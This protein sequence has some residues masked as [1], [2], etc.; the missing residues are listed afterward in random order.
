MKFCLKCTME[1]DE[2]E[3]SF[4]D[5]YKIIR[6]NECRLCI[7]KYRAKYYERNR[8]IIL[9][10][11][12]QRYCNNKDKI[13]EGIR[14]YRSNNKLII[15]KF[16]KEYYKNN[17]E[18][19]RAYQFKNKIRIQN[20]VNKQRC[21]RRKND[22]FYRLRTY[23]SNI[24]RSVLKTNKNNNG[25]WKNISYTP[26][27]LKEHLESRFE[28]WMNWQNH[29]RYVPNVWDD[30][31]QS[32]WTWQLDHII[33]QSD[34]PYSSMEDDN[35]KKCWDLE[36]LRPLSSKQNIIEGSSRTRHNA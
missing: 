19:I 12:N 18:L 33:P 11:A 14:N 28:P 2:S 16:K 26:Q 10:N 27:V 23:V 34:L 17:K 30:E 24:V 25:T 29:G 15:S 36:N 21:G 22:P 32:T 3:F 1:K 6:R 20:S 4:R 5:K 9:E 8:N 35:F 31:D 13:L 7:K